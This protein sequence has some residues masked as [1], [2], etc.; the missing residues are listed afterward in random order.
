MPAQVHHRM[1]GARPAVA[2]E[3]FGRAFELGMQ[4]HLQAGMCVEQVQLVGGLE[5]LDAAHQRVLR[6]RHFH[7]V[8]RDGRVGDELRA[9]R[10]HQV[11]RPGR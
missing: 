4:Q 9:Q 8:G 5:G 7:A 6:V 3:A 2:H 10:L 11:R 1:T